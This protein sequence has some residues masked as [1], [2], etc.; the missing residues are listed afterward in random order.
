MA[1][2]SE[3]SRRGNISG[4]GDEGEA[5]AR[6]G[7]GRRGDGGGTGSA[8]HTREGREARFSRSW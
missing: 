5:E 4:G 6:S 2:T 8:K 1:G 7:G 3:E